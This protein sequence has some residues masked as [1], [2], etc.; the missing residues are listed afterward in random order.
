M[1]WFALVFK[2]AV[3]VALLCL[4]VV[5]A[6]AQTT[7]WPYA[8]S[9]DSTF[10]VDSNAPR[11]FELLAMP[12]FEYTVTSVP[13]TVDISGLTWFDVKS[14]ATD[15]DPALFHTESEETATPA[16]RRRPTLL[17]TS[18]LGDGTKVVYTGW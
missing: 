18:D 3:L 16:S 8:T 15:L 1:R 10:S 12:T 17:I 14:D 7:G 13:D 9:S 6:G 2:V 5:D 4:A 11:H